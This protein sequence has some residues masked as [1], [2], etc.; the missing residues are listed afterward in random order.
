MFKPSSVVIIFLF[1]GFWK[2]LTAFTIPPVAAKKPPKLRKLLEH[3][4][5]GKHEL[6]KPRAVSREVT[7]FLKDSMPAADVL[8]LEKQYLVHFVGLT[9]LTGES[10]A[11]V[12]QGWLTP[13][14]EL[15]TFLA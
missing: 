8:D 3:A 4:A 13:C 14:G 12:K 1:K 11:L 9:L 7:R 15:G 10:I 6:V 5:G 2:R